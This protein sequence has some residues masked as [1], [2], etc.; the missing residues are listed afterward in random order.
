M[1]EF[2]RRSEISLSPIFFQPT[3]FLV[4]T[5]VRSE[6]REDGDD[7]DVDDDVEEEEEEDDN[8]EDVGEVEDDIDN[9]MTLMWNFSEKIKKGLEKVFKVNKN[10]PER[11]KETSFENSR[12][13][14]NKLVCLERDNHLKKARYILH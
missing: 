10:D 7:S 14:K 12:A 4:S 5:D 8:V 2:F 11:G 1:A 3:F 13:E 9:D 6:N